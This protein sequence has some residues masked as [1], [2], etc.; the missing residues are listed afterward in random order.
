MLKK[1]LIPSVIFLATSTIANA[2]APYVGLK[3][4]YSNTT[5]ALTNPFSVSTFFNANGAIGGAF[6]GYGGSIG[7]WV[8]L[9]IET[10]ITT[11]TLITST[12]QTGFG[13]FNTISSRYS[14]GLD[15]NPGL[16]LNSFMTLFF[17]F[18]IIKTRFNLTQSPA[19]PPAQGS[20]TSTVFSN[21]LGLGL[22]ASI[23]K[24]VSARLEYIHINYRSFASLGNRIRPRSDQVLLGLAYN[25][26]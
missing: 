15:I 8:Y 18:G 2:A 6:L 5:Y 21:R 11:G 7:Q 26:V 16:N 1:I 19:T 13:T 9:G 4:G 25:F 23:N 14:Y 12:K 3:A 20:D 24:K 22:Q 17:K 10:F